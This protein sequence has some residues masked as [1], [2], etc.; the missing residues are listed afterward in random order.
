MKK[1]Y[2]FMLTIC[3]MLSSNSATAQVS[4]ISDMFGKYKFTATIET[5][6]AGAAHADKFKSEC[7][8]TISKAASQ[9]FMADISGFAGADY[10]MSV[11]NFDATTNSIEI[12]GPNNANYGIWNGYIA[13]ANE[14][15]DWPFSIYNVEG[16]VQYGMTLTY[17]PATKEITVPDFTIVSLSWSPVETATLLA[18]VKNA[19]MVL[20]EAENIDTSTYPDITGEWKFDGEVRNEG[21]SP[22]TFT[23]NLEATD[24]TKTSWN[25]T[26][27][28]EGYE[29]FTL[30]AT[31]D[32]S[33]LTAPFDT[34]FLD[35]ENRIRF[36]TRTSSKEYSSAFTF[37]YN[38]KTSM[39]LYDYIYVR[40]DSITPETNELAGAFVH[41][42]LSGY[43]VRENPDAYDW[44]GTYNISVSSVED[45]NP[46]DAFEAASEFDMVIEKK[47]GNIYQITK[48]LGYEDLSILFTP[49]EDDKSANIELGGYSGAMLE[50]IGATEDN[51][52]S[53][54]V[55]TDA[56]GEPT[57]LKV[58]LNDDGSLSFEDFT[59]SYKLYY[60]NIYE[61]LAI[62]SGV[63]AN[64]EIFDW[65]GSYTLTADVENH[66]EGATYP[67]EFDV[68]IENF[69]GTYLITHFMDDKV[70]SL[71]YGGII[72]NIAENGQSA[73][74][75]SGKLIG[76]SYP[77]YL[78]LNSVDGA[79][80]IMMVL[81]SDGTVS[82]ADF[83]YSTL[84][85]ET[86]ETGD[87]AKYSNILLTKKS[88]VTDGIEDIETDK[89]PNGIYDLRGRSINQITSPGIYIINGKKV[90]VK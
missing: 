79:S 47:P 46:N 66:T 68:K 51:D 42:V 57:T 45:L 60:A 83:K 25:A 67:A 20:V 78:S 1:F 35:R 11:S 14:N 19:K 16:S 22:T 76:G 55:I 27:T 84:N 30:P 8:V 77:N 43:I 7:E 80:E 74:F 53:Y 61:P 9:Y 15:G 70:Y 52:Y 10:A 28:F 86:N 64:K 31:F 34:I 48:M 82:V 37:S 85:Y 88:D 59:V 17:D 38:S 87:V 21:V 26:F 69:N 41:Q 73:K 49:A 39:S 6:E 4:M 65:A 29:T 36:G 12:N 13:V 56:N 5:T 33:M 40:R 3:L 18:T 44:S 2:L 75:A 81:N 32:G 50:F 24:D 90:L 63:K 72:V 23:M 71:N 54:H 58:T 62:F 89:K